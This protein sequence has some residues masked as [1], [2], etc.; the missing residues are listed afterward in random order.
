MQNATSIQNPAKSNLFTTFKHFSEDFKLDLCHDFS[1]WKAETGRCVSKE[2]YDFDEKKDYSFPP[3]C[4]RT[5]FNCMDENIPNL[6]QY[7]PNRDKSCEKEHHFFCNDSKTC[8][9]NGN[10]LTFT[11]L[12]TK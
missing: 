1:F 12:P 10:Y 9:P 4:N 7:C 2:M 6:K 5:E 3:L 8:I 11:F